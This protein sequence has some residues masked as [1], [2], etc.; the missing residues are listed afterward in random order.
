[1]DPGR[2]GR[3]H[4]LRVLGGVRMTA[5]SALERARTYAA[6]FINAGDRWPDYVPT[7]AVQ[8]ADGL[9]IGGIQMERS[10]SDGG[11]RLTEGD[12]SWIIRRKATNS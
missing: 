9:W 3:L 10:I 6:I 7:D 2:T 5:P 8:R 1:M 4:M 12:H 11:W